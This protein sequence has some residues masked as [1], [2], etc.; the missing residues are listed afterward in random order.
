[1]AKLTSARYFHPRFPEQA[2]DTG[3][4]LGRTN[5]EGAPWTAAPANSHVGRFRFY[6]AREWSF[7]QPPQGDGRSKL[8]V[9]FK[10]VAAKK[11]RKGRPV[12]EY[13]YYFADA[14]AGERWYDKLC[15]AVHPGELIPGIQAACDQYQQTA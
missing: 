2:I 13:T 10:A 4:P 8:Q 12:S 7:L 15:G 3:K 11:R 9:R 1:M 5:S 14:A 6:D